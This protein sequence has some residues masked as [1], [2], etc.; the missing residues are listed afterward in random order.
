MSAIRLR[1]KTRERRFILSD[2][3]A[4]DALLRSRGRPAE[5]IPGRP[6]TEITTV[7]FDTP[8]GTWSQ[9]R[10]QTKLRAR[11]YQD[12]ATWWFEL[13]RREDA[14]VEKWRCPMSPDEVVETLDGARRWRT[15]RRL[16]GADPLV[17]LFAVRC[18]RVAFEW[19]G[20]RVTL[21]RDL[22]FHAV[23]PAHPLEVGARLAR[24]D[25]V[26]VEVKCRRGAPSWL[27]PALDGCEVADF[28]KSRYALAL[29][30]GAARPLPRQEAA[31][32]TPVG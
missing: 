20:L 27:L 26:V 13:K 14:N 28:S 9:G 23:E 24:L 4:L 25:G 10:S 19:P 11:S 18:R 7:Y 29:R 5:Y 30:A 31:C 22:A 16:V 17:A 1:I 3:G 32:L 12:P 15:A 2:V 8:K 6:E 21:D